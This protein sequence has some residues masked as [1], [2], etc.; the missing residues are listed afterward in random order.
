MSQSL[1]NS[2]LP[3]WGLLA[4]ALLALWVVPA[5][6]GPWEGR[7]RAR[8]IGRRFAVALGL[9]L[10][11]FL[12]LSMVLQLSGEPLE[13][14]RLQGD[15]PTWQ[16]FWVHAVLL[17]VLA[18]FWVSR[19]GS[20]RHE[21][22][23]LGLDPRLDEMASRRG[24]SVSWRRPTDFEA[25]ESPENLER[26]EASPAEREGDWRPALARE[27]ALG[28]AVGLV[29]WAGVLSILLL[30]SALI[31]RAFGPDAL[32]SAPPE[33]TLLV[34]SLPVLLRIGLALSAGIFEEAFFRGLLQPRIGVWPSTLLFVLAHAS[35]GQP[36]VLFGIGL[37][38]LLFA[39]LRTWRGSVYAAIAAHA[40]FDLVQLLVVLPLAT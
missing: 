8:R 13:L 14:S 18:A 40:V 26:N 21:L 32:P 12:P 38:S 7:A 9:W 19:S 23:Q 22:R 34:A 2:F 39:A 24:S 5:T 35:Y 28:A 1:F 16:F 10:A 3:W 25:R 27:L 30:V 4:A 20:S 11:V 33:Q 31:L 29:L 17:L 37:L 36:L 6:N 15:V